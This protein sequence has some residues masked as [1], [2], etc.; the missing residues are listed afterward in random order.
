MAE[1]G[2]QGLVA[3]HY[4]TG[5]EMAELERLAELC[6][7]H[8]HLL[9]RLDYNLLDRSNVPTDDLFL[10]YQ[11]DELVGC[12]LLDRYHSDIK[13]VS[14]G[15]HPAFR[16]RGIFSQLLAAARQECLSRSIHRLLFACETTS[17]SGQAFLR[18]IGGEREFAEHRM[19]LK[20]FQPRFQYDDHLLFRE[21]LYDDLED[22]SIIL[23]GDF[24]GDR[25]KARQHILRAFERPNQ[26]FYIATY[27][28]EDLGC[29]EPVGTLRIEEMPTEMG[30][31]GF[32][33]RQEYRGRGHG[34]QILEEAIATTRET[35]Q[36]LIMLEVDTN[37]FT[38]LNL[39]RSLGFV[40]ERTYEY[41]ALAL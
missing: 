11:E 18:V 27:G 19:I 25:E 30:I 38:A 35:S 36:K 14:G 23:A 6:N 2:R 9:M 37:N 8:E 29:A 16:R 17:I 5:R 31:Y 4:L 39:Y 34:R 10:F 13:E 7:E 20:D 22:L 40:V 32:F 41:Y 21:A 33:V 3:K 1:H 26:R 12:L 24:A 15:V 28:G